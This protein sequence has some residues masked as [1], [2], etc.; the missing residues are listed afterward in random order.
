MTENQIEKKVRPIGE[1]LKELMKYYNLNMNSLSIKLGLSSNSVITRVVKDPERGMSL[2][3]I[4]RILFEFPNISA[5][6]LILDK[7]EMLKETKI[8]QKIK[9]EQIQEPCNLCPLK[10]EINN[11]TKE[12]IA[13]TEK[14]L[15][16]REEQLEE[17]KGEKET[18]KT[19]ASG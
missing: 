17:Y 3:Y 14:I 16:V 8:Q 2:E 15:K 5:D 13:L 9:S 18:G 6:W 1:R 19:I 12:K 10:D 4:Q 7:G 11:L